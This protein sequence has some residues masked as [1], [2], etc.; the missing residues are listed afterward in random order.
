[1]VLQVVTD[2]FDGMFSS[3]GPNQKDFESVVKDVNMCVDEDMNSSLLKPFSL[4][5]IR[6]AL[7]QTDRT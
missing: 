1:M 2:Y 5:D 3:S 7:K 6:L 4:E